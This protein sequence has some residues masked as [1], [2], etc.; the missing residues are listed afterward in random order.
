ML[1]F[2][3]I[4]SVPLVPQVPCTTAFVVVADVG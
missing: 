1:V 3:R 4:M 2:V